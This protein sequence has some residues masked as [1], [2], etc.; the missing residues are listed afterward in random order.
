[1]RDQQENKLLFADMSEIW[2]EF[3][4]NSDLRSYFF[5]IG[6]TKADGI[7]HDN[8]IGL[9]RENSSRF[10]ELFL[11]TISAAQKTWFQI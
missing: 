1:M 4:R 11:T 7:K 5:T 9:I 3:R 10:I 2:N 8:F 6:F